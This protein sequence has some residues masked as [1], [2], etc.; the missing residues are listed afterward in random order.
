[1]SVFNKS[2][3]IFGV[4]GVA[5]MARC[6][7]K[8]VTGLRRP[9]R[10]HRTDGQGHYRSEYCTNTSDGVAHIP[11]NRTAT[12]L[13]MDFP[14]SDNGLL[15]HQYRSIF[16]NGPFIN[17]KAVNEW[18]NRLIKDFNIKAPS[19]NAPA[20]TL[21]GGNQQKLILA[22]EMVHEPRLLLAVQPTRGLDIASIEM[23]H[24]A[25]IEASL[26]GAILL[27]LTKARILSLSDRIAVV[28][29]GRIAGIGDPASFTVENRT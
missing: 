1:M 16:R 14:L 19:L 24:K 28:Y 5:E 15:G 29:S 17:R 27:S 9:L 21:S 18:I 2:G 13:V 23:I 11:A 26:A 22:R 6:P 4:V 12:G 3:E 20:F 7:G 8:A 25:L 10:T